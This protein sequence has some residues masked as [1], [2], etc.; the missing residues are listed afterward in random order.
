MKRTLLTVLISLLCVLALCACGTAPVNVPQPKFSLPPA[1]A[2]VTQKQESNFRQRLL[3]FFSPKPA[4]QTASSTS[5]TPVK[6]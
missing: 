3:G 5:S 6:Q 2:S 4:E 1:P